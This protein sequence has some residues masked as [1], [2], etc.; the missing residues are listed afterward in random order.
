MTQGQEHRGKWVWL[1]CVHISD[2]VDSRHVWSRNIETQA[3]DRIRELTDML[4]YLVK[5][6]AGV[7]R[8]IFRPQRHESLPEVPGEVVLFADGYS[9]EIVAIPQWLQVNNNSPSTGQR[10]GSKNVYPSRQLKQMIEERS[11]V[12]LL[13]F[14]ENVYFER[15]VK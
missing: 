12:C 6:A 11:T 9:Y 13:C 5:V 1:G 14:V 3:E 15:S 8:D 10:T 2:G 4:N 7:Q